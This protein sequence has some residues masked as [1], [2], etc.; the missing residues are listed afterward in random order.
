M[1]TYHPLKPAGQPDGE[2]RLLTL[3]PGHKGSK[4]ECT[5]QH[6]SF[7]SHPLYWALSYTWDN[8]KGK[9]NIVTARG[10]PSQ[11]HRIKLDEKKVK[12]TYNLKAAFQMISHK[13]K[14]RTL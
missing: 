14:S 3:L 7:A 12:V 9:L 5:L 6:V 11:T 2:F 10:D 13:K 8:P 4:I 1:H